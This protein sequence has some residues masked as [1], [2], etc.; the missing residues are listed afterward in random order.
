MAQLLRCHR[1]EQVLGFC[2]ACN[3]YGIN[4]SC[5]KFDFSTLDWL[6][7]FRHALLI[8][9]VVPTEA[10]AAQRD[11]L[12]SRQYQSPTYQ[13]Y[14]KSTDGNLYTRLSM[15]AFDQIK[16]KLNRR[17]LA[18]EA[19][20]DSVVS[21]PPGSCS[22]CQICAKKG[23]K[24]CLHPAK[25]RYSLEALGFLVS[26]LLDVFFDYQI[27]WARRDFGTDFVTISGLFSKRALP[28]KAVRDKL[29]DIVLEL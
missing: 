20:D 5:P 11:L 24:P 28:E 19:L 26:E 10:L 3:N 21:I 9:T 15:Y 29:S 13:K 22:Y 12:N 27:D 6:S 2:K 25:L 8:L 17:L 18:L 1:P 7:R 16:D 4:Y 14:H 23:G